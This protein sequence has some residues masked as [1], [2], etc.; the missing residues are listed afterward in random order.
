MNTSTTLANY[1]IT[2]MN[3]LKI[4]SQRELARMAGLSYAIV[5]DMTNKRIPTRPTLDKLAVAL[6]VNSDFLADLA[7]LPTHEVDDI[8]WAYRMV[9]A[10]RRYSF[11]NRAERDI[12]TSDMKQAVRDYERATRRVLL[13]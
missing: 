4:P 12:T 7:G 11:A 13:P 10:D 8:L 6:E 2:R 1:I 3:E 5:N 9:R